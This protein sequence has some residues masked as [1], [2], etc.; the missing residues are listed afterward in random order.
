MVSM[1]IEHTDS[2]PQVAADTS[3][4]VAGVNFAGNIAGMLNIQV[5][6]DFARQM[7]ANMLDMEPEEIEGDGEIKD[8]LSEI[9]NIVGGN[10]KSALN[11]A[12]LACVLSTPSMTYGGDFTIKSLN[13]ERF[14]RF[15]FM[16]QQDWVVVEV[17]IKTQQGAGDGDGLAAMDTLGQ[18]KDVDVEKVNAIDINAQVA[19]SVIDVFDTMFSAT[20]EP[21]DSIT[22]D[23]LKG[24]RNVG[25]VSLA[26][27]VTGMIS[28]HVSEA[29]AQEMAAEMLGMEIDEI[30]GDEE[31][32]DMLGE[33]GNIVGGSL[34]S[35]FTDAGL[36]CVLSTPSYTSGTDFK[37]EALNM[38]KY[39]RFAFKCN[40]SIVF[41]ELGIKICELAQVDTQ[42]GKDIH[43]A[44]DDNAAAEEAAPAADGQA[45]PPEEKA[46][47]SEVVSQSDI[48]ALLSEASIPESEDASDPPAAIPAER[49]TSPQEPISNTPEDV[50][51]GLLLDIP[52]EIKVE[53]GRAKIQIHELLNLSPGSA[54][55]LLKLEGEPVDILANDTLIARGEV[56]VQQEKYGI[57]VT[58]ITSRL[59]RIRS[60]GLIVASWIYLYYPPHAAYLLLFNIWSIRFQVS[61]VRC[62]DELQRADL[63]LARRSFSEI[64]CPPDSDH[65][66]RQNMVCTTRPPRLNASRSACHARHE[67][68]W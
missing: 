6:T 66:V 59:N 41:V 45:D 42:Q 35:S 5:T 36:T 21:A 46:T 18:L 29:F 67:R 54:V 51:L 37:I 28:I 4:V 30:E 48:D 58:E 33:V 43:Y 63:C 49:P 9:S 25:S 65:R 40:E 12:D 15:V 10:L 62:Q 24:V 61:G 3:R 47:A 14:E 57:R 60:F 34:K 38:T 7:T 26:G 20:L 53:L 1:E 31:V 2:E 13:M 8:L 52:L 16:N 68:S 19:E 64:R 27:D 32:R 44:V 39:E 17:G 23:S 50:D 56:V 55:K 11:D 22:S